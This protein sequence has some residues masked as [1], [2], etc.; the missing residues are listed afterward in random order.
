MRRTV[1]LCLAMASW[2]GP[3][4]ADDK[5]ACVDA[6]VAAQTHL[7]EHKLLGAREDMMACAR[8]ACEE[9]MH[10][11]VVRDC[12]DWLVLVQARIPTVVLSASSPSLDFDRASVTVSIDGSDSPRRIEGLA[13]EIEP[14]L[15]TFVFASGSAR[16][17]RSFVVLEGVKNQLVEQAFPAQVEVAASLAPPERAAPVGL[18]GGPGPFASA[19]S[20]VAWGVGAAGIGVG[21]IFGLMALAD[22]AKLDQ[23]CP[24]GVC[25]PPAQPSDIDALHTTSW[26]ANVG[27]AV[28]AAGLLTGLVLW[29]TDRPRDPGAATRTGSPAVRV[30]PLVGLS[31]VGVSGSFE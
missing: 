23:S 1:L 19:G 31:A 15:H 27:F 5:A 10:G 12:T 7:N 8:A 26:I 18:P 9:T 11:Q 4:R 6:Y 2:T 16:R 24:G 13:F 25:A 30:L 22:K 3:A 29:A 20:L 21:T 17:A 28:G 14:G